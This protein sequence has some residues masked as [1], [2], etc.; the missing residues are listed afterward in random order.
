[1]DIGGTTVGGTGTNPTGGPTGTATGGGTPAATLDCTLDD[2]NA[3]LVWCE[4][5]LTAAG[6]VTLELSAPG[7]PTRTFVS[8]E[9]S[10]EHTILAWGLRADTVYDFAAA[11]LDGIVST[12]SLPQGFGALQMDISGSFSG[13]DGVL[14]P[15]DCG[16]GSFVIFDSEGHVIW[17]TRDDLYGDAMDAYDWVQQT[18]TLLIA[19]G[20][21]VV[22]VNTAG[23]TTLE[24]DNVSGNA[25]HDLDWW[26][27]Y[28]YVL[29]DYSVSGMNVDGIHVYDGETLVD[30]FN[31]EDH[32]Q[33]VGGGAFGDWSHA[34]GVNPTENGEIILSLL[35]FDTVMSIDGDPNSP[36]F[37]DILWQVEGTNDGLP[38]TD[39]SWPGTPGSGFGG[40]HNA[41][42]V[43]DRLWLFDNAGTYGQS[44][45][46]VYSL[47]DTSGGLILE[48]DWS[49][50]QYCSFQGGAERVPGG[51]LATCAPSRDVMYFEEGNDTP[52]WTFNADCDSGGFFAGAMNRAVP[53]WVE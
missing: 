40:Q 53:V 1:V 19:D 22:H 26:N 7:A 10:T 16:G 9:P 50:G 3:L 48:E 33:L 12:G 28:T 29:H 46:A 21:K 34:N 36:T 5:S 15:T 20:P 32:F 6:P 52:L 30:T 24:L 44:R 11:G 27:G 51:V 49:V 25:H 18:Q 47:D 43:E 23:E 45:A 38:G 41:Q 14:I 17:Y 42:F 2:V 4:V 13:F 31:L 37:L 39:Y 8:E 35:N